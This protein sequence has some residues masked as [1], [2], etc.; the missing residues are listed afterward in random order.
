MYV[1]SQIES[2][3]S[4]FSLLH[5]RCNHC[6]SL[7]ERLSLAESLGHAWFNS[8]I[9]LYFLFICS[10]LVFLL[11]SGSEP[12]RQ[13]TSYQPILEAGWRFVHSPKLVHLPSK[14]HGEPV[15]PFANLFRRQR[16]LP[17]FRANTVSI[18][19]SSNFCCSYSALP[20]WKFQLI[21]LLL[22]ASTRKFPEYTRGLPSGLQSKNSET[23]FLTESF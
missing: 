11:L 22:V 8:N 14:H 15:R 4:Y 1:C 20:S 9:E 3:F 6:N 18:I 23:S 10:L 2:I 7:P 19:S 17:E 5:I 16:L 13:I 12:A 21:R